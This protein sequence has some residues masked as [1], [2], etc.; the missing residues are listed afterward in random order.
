M[1][2]IYP[3][4]EVPYIA[5]PSGGRRA[6]L[7]RM[8]ASPRARFIFFDG[9]A[10]NLAINN[11]LAVTYAGGLNV[12]AIGGEHDLQTLP[13]NPDAL[14]RG[15]VRVLETTANG[16]HFLRWAP[17]NQLPNVQ[18]CASI[19]VRANGRTRGR[20][21]VSAL[22]DF[23]ADV[24]EAE[25]DLS[26]ETITL[27]NSGSVFNLATGMGI[28]PAGNSWYRV[29]IATTL[30]VTTARVL[31]M[32]GAST[33]YVGSTSAGMDVYA[34]QIET[35]AA[36]SP[37]VLTGAR[38]RHHP[39][40][41][42]N[43]LPQP[44]GMASTDSW[45]SV[46]TTATALIIGRA[47]DGGQFIAADVIE[48]TANA[49]HG[50]TSS[51]ST[52]LSGVVTFSVYARPRGAS[53]NRRLLLSVHSTSNAMS[54]TC[55]FNFPGPAAGLN[56]TQTGTAAGGARFV[57]ARVE[58]LDDDWVRCI[59]TAAGAAAAWNEVRLRFADGVNTTYTGSTTAGFH[60]WGAELVPGY[61][62]NQSL[63]QAALPI[64]GLFDGG[65]R[66]RLAALGNQATYSDAATQERSYYWEVTVV[67]MG[68]DTPRLGI[69]RTTDAAMNGTSLGQVSA[70]WALLSSGN[71]QANG[72]TV[73]TGPTYTS[74]DTLAFML[75]WD[76]VASRFSLHIVK[77]PAGAVTLPAASVANIIAP[78][79]AA[80]AR[81]GLTSETVLDVNFGQRPFRG[82]PPAGFVPLGWDAADNA[83]S[84]SSMSIPVLD[85]VSY[86][87]TLYGTVYQACMG[88]LAS[89]PVFRRAVSCWV[90]G[91]EDRRE[92]V[93]ALSLDNTDGALDALSETA[94]RD[95]TL[96]LHLTRALPFVAV[97][98]GSRVA[99]ALIDQVS[100]DGGTVT[101]TAR[102]LAELLT[103]PLQSSVYPA[104]VAN[105]A[106]RGKP[107]PIVL[108]NVR[109]A[110]VVMRA[111][112]TL[113]FDVHE[114]SAFLAIDEVR[115][116]GALL[117]NPADWATNG[118]GFRRATAVQG[119][120][121]ARVRGAFN[122]G[123]VLIERLPALLTWI[124]VTETGRLTAAQLDTA[125]SIT[126]L[127]TAAP[128]TLARY[129]GPDEPIMASD[130]VR[131]IMDSFTG[132]LFTGADGVLRAWR[133]AVP[134]GTPAFTWTEADLLGE[135]KR[136]PDQARGLTTTIGFARNYCVHSTGEIAG[137][138][139]NTTLASELSL[140]FQ[141]RTSSVALATAYRQAVAAPPFVTLHTD[142]AQAQTEI[143]RVA[144]AY[145][146]DRAFYDAQ[147][148]VDSSAALAINPGTIVWLSAPTADLRQ[149]KLLMVVAI[150]GAL[151]SNAVTVTL[152][153]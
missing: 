37:P 1:T 122:T 26:A 62:P 136:R 57:A 48:T 25:F 78:L 153:G 92:P 2:S 143:D 96:S 83:R 124:A 68:A 118:E 103:V 39:G 13:A 140:P 119:K 108:G 21:G 115:Q 49:E 32:S 90:W 147:V 43:W 42:Q 65:L 47:P 33:S 148:M 3:A 88:R 45:A 73:G 102:D 146:V 125:G 77:N 128:Y 112:A 15:T 66:L 144:G 20:I 52:S 4:G 40:V 126:A 36:P 110:P 29:W 34:G 134:A 27:I 59:I 41:P 150:E 22:F 131:E 145:A 53:A 18:T 79:V 19:Y 120:Q 6:R 69:A 106:V 121:C 141:S 31:F 98:T 105:T 61:E 82:I 11:T 151:A 56:F 137:A 58:R 75:Q 64:Q 142:G 81:E 38:T 87:S 149:G 86:R 138:I 127:D 101:I 109:W 132:D 113:D 107:R 9:A 97:N 51:S 116:N 114:S 5:L 24:I 70:T 135:V 12:T 93:S 129:I 8:G 55:G 99:T 30:G 152:W 71:V 35:A 50:I 10:L 28:E 91:R 80:V 139:Q 94:N 60:L 84:F 76:S 85:N 95:R 72:I 67:S 17:E 133:F 16:A 111:P 89:R 130:L 100:Q 123:P 63:V 14:E 23:S 46:N 54:V 104:T 117:A 74:G 44:T 7:A